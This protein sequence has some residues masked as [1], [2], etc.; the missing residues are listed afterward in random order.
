MYHIENTAV[1]AYHKSLSTENA[2]G[3]DGRDNKLER[4]M[5]ENNKTKMNKIWM[6]WS[7][8]WNRRRVTGCESRISDVKTNVGVE[9]KAD[10]EYYAYTCIVGDGFIIIDTLDTECKVYPYYSEY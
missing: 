9:G 1:E 10:L 3:S 8:L 5:L 7:T 6:F 2:E 4:M